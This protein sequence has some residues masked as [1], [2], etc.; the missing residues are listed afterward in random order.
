MEQGAFARAGGHGAGRIARAI[1]DSIS[2]NVTV[3]KEK[4]QT[5]LAKVQRLDLKRK[6]NFKQN[7]GATT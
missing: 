2:S 7:K 1:R 3:V 4:F 5:E 6:R